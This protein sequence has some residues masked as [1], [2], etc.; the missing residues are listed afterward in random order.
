MQKCLRTVGTSHP[1]LGANSAQRMFEVSQTV[2]LTR[3]A[4]KSSAMPA[5][6]DGAHYHHRVAANVMAPNHQH[7]FCWRLDLDVDG[8]VNRVVEW[9]TMNAQPLL[10][11]A[12]GEWF[13]M[14]QQTL[15]TETAAQ[16]D[17]DLSTARRWLVV[18]SQHHNALGQ[19]TAYALVPGE[20]APLSLRRVRGRRSLRESS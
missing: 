4:M 8:A 14:Q 13:A 19:P 1:V 2:I 6:E 15:S 7:F 3:T 18:N 11:D 5:G 10:H 9:N 16:R 12:L 17:V 20:N